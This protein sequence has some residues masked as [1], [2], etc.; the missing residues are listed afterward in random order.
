LNDAFS[1]AAALLH[2]R[3]R[4]DNYEWSIRRNLR[5]VLQQYFEF[6]FTRR[7]TGNGGKHAGMPADRQIKHLEWNV[8]NYFYTPPRS[9]CSVFEMVGK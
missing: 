7:L 4:E 3:L 1:T 2:R 6:V 5:D 8:K 9:A